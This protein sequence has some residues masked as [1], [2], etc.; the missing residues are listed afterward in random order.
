MYSGSNIPN[1]GSL[2]LWTPGSDPSFEGVASVSM[3]SMFA[4]ARSI[5]DVSSLSVENVLRMDSMFQN[6]NFFDQ[7]ISGWNVASVT[8]FNSM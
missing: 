6:N 5:P 4:N 7:D 1:P 2:S 3:R 8:T